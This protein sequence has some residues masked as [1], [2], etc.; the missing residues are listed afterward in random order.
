MT[1]PTTDFHISHAGAATQSRFAGVEP[2]S[3]ADQ[4]APDPHLSPVGGGPQTAC[5]SHSTHDAQAGDAGAGLRRN[6]S[7][8]A[9]SLTK[10]KARTLLADPFLALAADVV[11]DAESTRIANENRLRQLTRLE[12]DSDGELRGFGLDESHPD[13]ARLAALVHT[14]AQVE[15]QATLNLNRLVRRHPLGPWAKA[16]RGV[17]DKQFARLLAV[18]GDPYWH[19]VHDRPRT[20]S[21][22]WSYCG[23]GDASR[24]R[25]RGMSQA[26]LFAL[27]DPVAKSRTYLIAVSC[28]KK[29]G[30]LADAYYAR[31]AVT[32]DRVHAVDC[33]RCGP[34]GSPALPGS[35]WS[36]GHQHGDA[37]RVLGK[38]FLRELWLEARRLHEEEIRP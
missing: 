21:E 25:A 20:V 32:A 1:A 10:P 8:A 24:R 5:T 37:L 34:S 15:H 22:L 18:V 13:V 17:G 28:L 4:G 3:P 11:D 14:L 33:R 2:S 19:P 27:G 6:G 16:Q 29:P 36:A 31:R 23:H 38:T 30:P 9:I 35:P 7:A 26:D 12:A